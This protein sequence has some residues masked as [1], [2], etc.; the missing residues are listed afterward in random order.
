MATLKEA[1]GDTGRINP[2]LDEKIKKNIGKIKTALLANGVSAYFA[3]SAFLKD[4]VMKN[5]HPV[6]KKMPEKIKSVILAGDPFY[7]Q[8]RMVWNFIIGE[9]D[10][11]NSFILKNGDIRIVNENGGL[12]S[13][14]PLFENK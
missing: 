14:N 7:I 9:L 10:Q 4:L 8:N 13:H 1:I 11:D 3:P 6:I 12:Q 2:N 5:E